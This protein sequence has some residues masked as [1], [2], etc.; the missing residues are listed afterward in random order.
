MGADTSTMT[1]TRLSYADNRETGHSIK[2][3][4]KSDLEKGCKV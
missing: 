2:Y 1:K 3:C 4:S